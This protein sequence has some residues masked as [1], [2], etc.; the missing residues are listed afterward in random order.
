MCAGVEHSAERRPPAA[1]H[2]AFSANGSSVRRH[3]PA[4][5]VVVLPVKDIAARDLALVCHFRQLPLVPTPPLLPSPGKPSLNV[6]ADE[7]V[8]AMQAGIN[9]F[10]SVHDRVAMVC[11]STRC[12]V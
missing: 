8:N 3:G 2:A 4:Q 7:F 12:S 5:P 10:S 9:K 6:L 1:A 11:V